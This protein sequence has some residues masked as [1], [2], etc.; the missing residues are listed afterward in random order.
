MTDWQPP[1][2]DADGPNAPRERCEHHQPSSYHSGKYRVM[3]ECGYCKRDARIAELEETLAKIETL[4]TPPVTMM[5]WPPP[6][7][8][9]SII[10]G[11]RRLAAAVG[12][13]T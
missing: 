5:P 10:E 6:P 4:A 8:P 13:E 7:I 12:E 1:T 11:I 9:T 2:P 3:A